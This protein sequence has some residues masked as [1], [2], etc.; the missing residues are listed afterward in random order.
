MHPLDLHIV[1]FDVGKD[2][3][4]LYDYLVTKGFNMNALQNPAAIHL[5]VTKMHDECVIDAMIQEIETFIKCKETL[6]YK[7]D[8]APIYGMKASIP[9]CQN[10]IL[11]DCIC[12]YLINKYST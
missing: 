9:V 12:S 2:T 10:E 4:K 5:C 6:Q 8:L 1:C 7:E 3:Y 11:N